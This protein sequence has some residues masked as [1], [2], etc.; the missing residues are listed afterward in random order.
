MVK[1]MLVVF[2]VI[3]LIACGDNG[4]NLVCR[5]DVEMFMSE[6]FQK[7]KQNDRSSLIAF[8]SEETLEN[9]GKERF[10]ELMYSIHSTFGLLISY[11]LQTV[12]I[13]TLSSTRG[14]TGR[15]FTLIFNN[16][17][18]NG[19]VV[20][21]ID[22]FVPRGESTIKIQNHNFTSDVLLGL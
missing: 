15:H 11:E 16:Q 9:V 17:Y 19:S 18:E 6:Y 13:R 10:K 14:F 3:F 8:Y 5:D 12:T 7:L 1:K 22:I 21:A 4:R 20:E 2:F